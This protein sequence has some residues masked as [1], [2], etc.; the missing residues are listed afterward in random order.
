MLRVH[1][2]LIPLHCYSSFLF[3]SNFFPF[4]PKLVA[5][6]MAILSM[7]QVSNAVSKLVVYIILCVMCK[8]RLKYSLGSLARLCTLSCNYLLMTLYYI[9]A[10]CSLYFVGYIP[11][12]NSLIEICTRTLTFDII[13]IVLIYLF[14]GK[15]WT[16]DLHQTR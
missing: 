9:F 4:S 12:L 3:N 2:L 7:T 14:C 11:N 10:L 1:L 5:R 15:I 16:V 13:I 6:Y 8:L